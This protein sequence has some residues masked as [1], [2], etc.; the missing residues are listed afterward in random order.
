MPISSS[1]SL[2][3]KATGYIIA[4]FK[5]FQYRTYFL[6]WIIKNKKRRGTFH[7]VFKKLPYDK[8]A[9]IA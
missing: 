2:P 8:P 3:W 1:F 5:P 6:E 7:S 9:L 4:G